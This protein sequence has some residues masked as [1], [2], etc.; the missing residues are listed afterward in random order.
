MNCTDYSSVCRT[1][2]SQN[3]NIRP[4]FNT[5][6]V[7]DQEITLCDMLMACAPITVIKNDGLPDRICDNCIEELRKAF[8]FRKMCENSDTTLRNCLNNLKPVI[9][10]TS[11]E[12]EDIKPNISDDLVEESQIDWGDNSLSGDTSNE[13][14]LKDV[15]NNTKTLEN[16]RRKRSYKCK[17]CN[18]ECLGLASYWKHMSNQ[19]GT[20]LKCE[21]CDKE[22][23]TP[24]LL[25]EHKS[26]CPGEIEPKPKRTRKRTGITKKRNLPR[27]CD[28]CHKTF[29][30]HSNLERHQL[31]HTGE[32]PYLCNVCGKGFG[33]LSYLKIHSFIHTGEKPY[34]CQMCDK[35]FAAPGTLMTHIRIHTGERPHVCKICGKDFPQSGYLSAHIRTHT[36]EKPV[37]CHV[38][39][40][41]FNQSGRLVI[42]MRI[43]SGEK[44]FSCNECGRSFAVKGTL[45][46]HIRT[47]TGERPYVCSVCGQAFAQSGTLAT[48]MKV[49]RPKP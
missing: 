26:S 12:I 15:E 37:E 10:Q 34:K 27:T 45:K 39:H 13:E 19:H 36:G 30:F 18:E 48:H 3:M 42:H 29:R 35:S 9:V 40:R 32:R 8:S 47:H 24:Y 20:K 21:F 23:R 16:G 22:F 43:H 38:C 1:C 7:L 46:K 2:M 6:E 28:V 5:K 33:Q 44:P 17:E 49:H 11:H 41:R 14:N 25:D 31:T 4:I